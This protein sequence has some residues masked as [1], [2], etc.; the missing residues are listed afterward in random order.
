LDTRI[1]SSNNE[2]SQV[3]VNLEDD[4]HARLSF[5]YLDYNQGTIIQ[6]VH[7]GTSSK[8]IVTFGKVKGAKLSFQNKELIIPRRRSNIVW[9]LISIPLVFLVFT[10]GLVSIFLQIV[11]GTINTYTSCHIQLLET[12]S[13]VVAGQN[14][15]PIPN[16]SPS[17]DSCSG[18]LLRVP[19]VATAVA[20][21]A[22]IE[23]QSGLKDTIPDQ[24]EVVLP[25]GNRLSITSIVGRGRVFVLEQKIEPPP[26]YFTR[27]FLIGTSLLIIAFAVFYS[28]YRWRKFTIIPVGLES[29][30]D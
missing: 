16:T 13:A 9:I 30:L 6:I 11:P 21:A 7:T 14:T 28:L 19:E 2:S 17:S 29:F 22:T 25:N 1:L 15:T 26:I 10:L 20:E 4:S 5:D 23:K 24:R 12:P 3:L 18:D 8:D 27:T